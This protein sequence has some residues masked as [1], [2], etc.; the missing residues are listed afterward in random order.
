MIEC[1]SKLGI[2][3]KIVDVYNCCVF[4]RC[5]KYKVVLSIDIIKVIGV[6]YLVIVIVVVKIIISNNICVV[7]LC[8]V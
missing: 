7:K 2:C 5:V 4:W 1:I 3:V 8:N 6:F